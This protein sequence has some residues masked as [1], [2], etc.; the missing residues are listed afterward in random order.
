VYI[1]TWESCAVQATLWNLVVSWVKTGRHN[2]LTPW[3]RVLFETLIVSH[4]IKNFPLLY[5][6][7]KLIFRLYKCPPS[8]PI[9]SQ[10]NPVHALLNNFFK[11]HSNIILT[12]TLTPSQRMLYQNHVGLCPPSPTPKTPSFQQP[13]N[14]KWLLCS[15]VSRSPLMY[16]V[17]WNFCLYTESLFGQIG[18]SNDKC[19]SSLDVECWRRN[20]RCT[21]V[22]DSI[23]MNSR[24]QKNLILHSS[25]FAFNWR[26]CTA[27]F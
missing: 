26:C 23:S 3:S 14:T 22:A 15:H 8:F 5:G 13:D 16:V 7:W 17:G 6:N 27:V 25:H 11:I 19:P 12:P 4:L 18:D 20:A 1:I 9:A 21:A 10:I 2:L 24:T